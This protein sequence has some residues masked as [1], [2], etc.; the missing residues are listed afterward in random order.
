MKSKYEISIWEDVPSKDG[1]SF[2]EE[3]IIIIGSDTMTS[4]SRA[5][6]PKMVNNINGTNKFS[7][8]MY[9]SYI[10]TRTGEKVYNPYIKYLVNERKIKV[11]WK[12]EWYDLLIKQI[13]E[14]QVNHVFTYTCEDAYITELSRT[15]FELVFSTEL[16]NNIGTAPELIEQTLKGTDWNL[17]EERTE[18]IYQQ[19]EEAVYEAITL[20]EFEA[21]KDVDEKQV[22]ILTSIKKNKPILIY[23]SYAPNINELK[24]HL[25]FYYAD[26][27]FTTDVNEMLVNNGASYTIDV[28]WIK[29]EANNQAIAKQ[30]D[31]SLFVISFTQGISREYRAERYVQSQQTKYIDILERYVNV[32]TDQNDKRVYGYQTTEYNDALAV[33]NLFT[34]PSNFANV[35]GWVGDELFFRLSPGFD[36]ATTIKDYTAASFLYLKSGVYYNMGLQHNRAYTPDGYIPGDRYILRFK[37]RLASGV[38]EPING[39]KITKD[40]N[41][42]TPS[43]ES[44]DADYNPT[45]TNYFELKNEINSYIDSDDEVWVEFPLTCVKACPYD[46][47]LSSD[48]PFGLFLKITAPVWLKEVQ[49]F[50][51]IYGE[52]GIRIEPG[53]MSTQSVAQVVWK[54]F[55][56]D[57]LNVDGVTATTLEYTY[58]SL[59]S[60]KD[61]TPVANNYERYGTIEADD[62][63]RFNILQTI[64][65]TFKCWVRFRVG[66]DQETGYITY[67]DE[68]LDDGTII[69]V[70]DKYVYLTRETGQETGI[71]FIYGIDLKSIVRTIKSDKISTKT[72]V[73]QNENEFGRNGFCTIARSEENYILDNFILNFDYYIQQ[74]LLDRDELYKDLYSG[75]LNYYNELHRLNSTYIDNLEKLNNKKLELTKQEAMLK[76]Y[77]QYK[78]A[79]IQELE[80]VEEDLMKLASVDNME[81]ALRYAQDHANF[82]K[83]QSLMN[84]RSTI[85]NTITTYDSLFTTL[86]TSVTSL[87]NFINE[88]QK[89]Q[90][91]I[92]ED[93]KKLN[94]KFFRKY[95][96][97]IQEGTWTSEDY[98]DDTL[99]YL[100]AL[101]VAYTSSRPQIQYEINV[102]R[103]SDIPEYS[104]KVFHLG[105]IS[106]IQDVEYFGYIDRFTPYKEKVILSEITSYF[107]TPDKDTIKVQNY[108]TQFD[109]LF[110]RIT[111]AVQNLEFTEGKYAKAASIVNSDGT[112]RSNVIQNT[113]AENVDL[114]Y[115]A[116]NE[117]ATI[118]NTGVT[119][120][121]NAD[122]SKQVK[123]T[124]G[125][126]FITSDGGMTWNNA[127]RGDGITADVITTGRLNTEQV[128][129]YGA[130]APSFTWDQYGINAYTLNEN[131]GETD[132]TQ[133]VRF[134]KYGLYGIKG[135]N[136][137]FHPT[138]EQNVYEKANFGLTWNRFFM[139]SGTNSGT[140]V[141]IS[142]DKDIVVT[143]DGN[144]R[145]I[146]G[147]VDPGDLSNYGILVK[148]KNDDGQLEEVFRCDKDGASLAGW[149]LNERCLS[150]KLTNNQSIKIYS[151]GNIGCYGGAAASENEKAYITHVNSSFIA[152][153]LESSEQETQTIIHGSTIYPFISALGKIKTQKQVQG[154]GTDADKTP[155]GQYIPIPPNTLY[156]AYGPSNTNFKVQVDWRANCVGCKVEP[157][158]EEE[159]TIYTTYTYTFQFIASINGIDLFAV[160]SYSGTNEKIPSITDK[161]LPRFIPAADTKWCIDNNGDAIFHNIMAD[162]GQIAGWWIDSQSIYQTYDGTSSR[163]RLVDGR[164]VSNIKTELSSTGTAVKD[165]FD[166][167]IVTDAI[168]A[169]MASVGGM[170]MQSGTINGYNIARVAAAAAEAAY[171]ASAAQTAADNAS[172][173]IELLST[174][175][176]RHQH[177][178]SVAVGGTVSGS[179][180]RL[181]RDWYFTTIPQK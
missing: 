61:V 133:F 166:Y 7:F 34:N 2:K 116:Q 143:Q 87:T 106:F 72:I 20:C 59:E 8:N 80:S 115:G 164:E 151:D 128:V 105:D 30:G 89:D 26:G 23:Y 145:I 111:A 37:A 13:K 175:F 1:V 36:K 45:G 11:L 121:N 5:R 102:L 79:A 100:D 119:V 42:I 97:Y 129:I 162:G 149:T 165:N 32:Y 169:S 90:N 51:E 78:S 14:D 114:V 12:D 55:T 135:L 57:A 107:D 180:V 158:K 156:F 18:K 144:Q 95:S 50:H 152:T 123:V 62:S 25:Q 29:D 15:G 163:T 179:D 160:P 60:W 101:Q 10:D 177:K 6:E 44:R 132:Y 67:H 4:E 125:G 28:T 24:T 136:N 108:K 94:A 38:E 69:S 124:S 77:E 171:A 130:D 167:S 21:L 168:N 54:Y 174:N 66:H 41:V 140:G 33:V 92:I 122:G 147:R 19:T 173:A 96:R 71:G 82:T 64:A 153:N 99:Y 9:Y 120:T 154:E 146:I 43:I 98:W 159:I 155:T 84:D 58:T 161:E 35:S 142:T 31:I 40:N 148:N 172:K 170:L 126:V 22:N 91:D 16:E 76:V 63:N 150:S 46:E 104:S 113:F 70:P 157:Y 103:L 81:D 52:G 118:D 139:K 27:N 178:V 86:Q 74:Q 110:Q 176:S 47:I 117:S 131:N 93:L 138:S 109:D 181:T 56:D 39:T 137:D 68:T 85:N 48:S 127:I 53:K 3:K 134:D 49:F 83:V 75:D 17:D 73:S 65:E 88:T 112:I 141:E